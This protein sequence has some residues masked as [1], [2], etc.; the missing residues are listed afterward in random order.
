MGTAQYSIQFSGRYKHRRGA[1]EVCQHC[2]E[3]FYVNPSRIGVK[4]FCS[5][6]CHS[7]SMTENTT[8]KCAT[9]GKEFATVKSQI[10]LRNRTHCSRKCRADAVRL[11]VEE[12]KRRRTQY[13]REHRDEY[14]ERGRRFKRL[15]PE[16]IRESAKRQQQK[17][18]VRLRHRVRQ[19][20]R[21]RRLKDRSDGSITVDAINEMGERQG[22][23][24]VY[25]DVPIRDEFHI[26]HIHPVSRGGAHSIRNIQL[27]CAPC[28]LRKHTKTHDEYKTFELLEIA[29]KYGEAE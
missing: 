6:K 1:E 23:M 15:N 8:V 26:D 29:N 2:G 4:K 13:F 9:C 12:K 3:L 17:P 14:R 21:N 16:K 11:T 7:L 5:K 22:W 28:N 19:A 20:Q 10:T 25:C 27:L 18:E 24:C